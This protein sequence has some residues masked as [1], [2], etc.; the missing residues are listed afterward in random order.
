[1]GGADSS[2]QL[3]GLHSPI[4]P[5]SREWAVPNRTVG[6]CVRF[7]VIG[8]HPCSSNGHGSGPLE[9]HLLMCSELPGSASEYGR[10]HD[11][12]EGGG[13]AEVC[14]GGDRRPLWKLSLS[15]R[16]L[17]ATVIG[18]EQILCARTCVVSRGGGAVFGIPFW[19]SG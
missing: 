16:C 6:E 4:I 19:D 2:I 13:S 10:I 8:W 11:R 17:P 14:Y 7:D 15:S 18:L 5:P 3:Y 12:I 9:E 1:V